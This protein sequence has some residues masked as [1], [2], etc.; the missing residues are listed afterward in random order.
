MD[1]IIRTAESRDY[2]EIYELIETA[3]STAYV[4]DG[5][6]QD[7]AVNLRNSKNH[8]RDLEL[9]MEV[10]D[11]IIGYVMMTKLSTNEAD[12]N[13]VLLLAPICI[14][15]EYRNNQLGEKLLLEGLKRAT[16]L[17]YQGV[18][19]LGDPKFYSRVGF[20]RASELGIYDRVNELPD[21]YFLGIELKPKFADKKIFVDVMESNK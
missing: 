20:I 11:I 21:E 9:V 8:I 5:T 10:D 16:E 14:A 13:E 12:S 15:E 7:F 18:F 17:D 6:E 4:S 2:D 3:F 1:Y 19:L